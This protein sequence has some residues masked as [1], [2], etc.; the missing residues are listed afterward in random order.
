MSDN[1]AR[2]LGQIIGGAL[3]FYLLFKLF[4]FIPRFRGFDNQF[5]DLGLKDKGNERDQD[6]DARSQ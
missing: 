2:F 4:S 1:L 5:E 6:Q 3:F